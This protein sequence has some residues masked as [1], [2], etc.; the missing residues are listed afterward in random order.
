MLV[1]FCDSSN[2]YHLDRQQEN[3]ADYLD[4]DYDELSM[5]VQ[6]IHIQS[7]VLT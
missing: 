6:N 1:G 4:D 7:H 5:K 3:Q 2:I